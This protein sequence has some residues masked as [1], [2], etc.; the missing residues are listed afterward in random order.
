MHG[1]CKVF[2]ARLVQHNLFAQMQSDYAA[3]NRN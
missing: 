2:I 3:T 1:I